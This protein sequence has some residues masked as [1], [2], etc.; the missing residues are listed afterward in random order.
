MF[1]HSICI[2]HRLQW[3][4]IEACLGTSGCCRICRLE[5]PS[6][7]ID[8]SKKKAIYRFY[9]DPLR[10]VDSKCSKTVITLIF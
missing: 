8:H 3:L 2:I 6:S 7:G 5:G 1:D 10:N 9:R 4:S